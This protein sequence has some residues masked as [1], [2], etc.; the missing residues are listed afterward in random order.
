MLQLKLTH[1]QSISHLHVQVE[2][3]IKHGNVSSN[4]LLIRYFACLIMKRFLSPE[5]AMGHKKTKAA[6]EPGQIREQLENDKEKC[7]AENVKKLKLLGKGGNAKVFECNSDGNLVVKVSEKYPVKEEIEMNNQFGNDTGY[8][9]NAK[10]FPCPDPKKFVTSLW[11]DPDLGPND[12]PT[13]LYD[14]LKKY[15]KDDE[16]MAALAEATFELAGGFAEAGFYNFDLTPANVFLILRNGEETNL[17]FKAIDFDKKFIPNPLVSPGGATDFNTIYYMTYLLLLWAIIV[18]D[19]IL[20]VIFW[21]KVNELYRIDLYDRRA[22][23]E[24]ID[25]LEEL[26]IIKGFDEERDY[27]P[28]YMLQH[29]SNSA[30]LYPEIDEPEGY[31][32]DMILNV[33]FP[34]KAGSIQCSPYGYS[35]M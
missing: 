8:R 19:K 1:I 13:K 25:K 33:L 29:Y 21:K 34:F 32:I 12:K 28:T 7:C 24:N 2:T 9:F 10:A 6:P 15:Y 11:G 23:K 22:V 17:D 35:F 20:W 26:A 3:I 18:N 30:K 16:A 4:H 31:T 27:V 14:F 5:E